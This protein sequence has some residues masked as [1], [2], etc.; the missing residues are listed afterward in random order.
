MHDGL[1]DLTAKEKEALRL[2]L[3]GHDTKSTAAELGL[4][5]HTINDRLR[6]A[7]RKL[8]VTSSREAARIL[9]DAE[10]GTPQFVAPSQLGMGENEGGAT[11][12]GHSKPARL[13]TRTLAWHAGGIAMIALVAAA[14]MLALTPASE[15]ASQSVP[16]SEFSAIA[17]DDAHSEQAA[18]DW[19]ALVDARQWEE[20][21]EATGEMFQSEVTA[22][23]WAETGTTVRDPLGAVQSR[24]VETLQQTENLHGVTEG[25]Y[26]VIQFSTAF[27]KAPNAVE[28][29]ILRAE[30]GALK[31]VG[32][33]IR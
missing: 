32:Y 13:S 17:A 33:F 7:L 24:E 29:V 23:Q 27:A 30:D 15:S 19:L 20:S 18:L 5:V 10:G 26:V 28:T 31:V 6:S 21:W 25:D 14:T 8:G 22:A 2:L 9:G 16:Q 12:A 11:L 3:A 4:S 1:G